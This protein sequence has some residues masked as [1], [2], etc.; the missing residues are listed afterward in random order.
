MCAIL[1]DPS[2]PSFVPSDQPSSSSVAPELPIVSDTFPLIPSIQPISSRAPDDEDYLFH[3]NPVWE[4]EVDDIPVTPT[5]A[6]SP[7]ASSGVNTSS[8]VSETPVVTNIEVPSPSSSPLPSR[9]KPLR[10]MSRSHPP[11]SSMWD[12][13]ITPTSGYFVSQ[14]SATPVTSV[15]TNLTMCTAYS[16]PVV[17]AATASSVNTPGTSPDDDELLIH[18]PQIVHPAQ[19]A[20]LYSGPW[21][22]QGRIG[23]DPDAQGAAYYYDYTIGQY[24]YLS[25]PLQNQPIEEVSVP[26]SITWN[27]TTFHGGQVMAEQ[28]QGPP[29]QGQLLY[30]QNPQEQLLYTQYP[31]GQL[32]YTQ[33]PQDQQYYGPP[34]SRQPGDPQGQ[35]YQGQPLGGGGPSF[36]H[37]TYPS[38]QLGQP[39]MQQAQPGTQQGYLARPS[40]QPYIQRGQ[41]GV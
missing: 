19:S 38:V 26:M 36:S 11:T 7:M 6:S 25:S 39:Y 13:H 15:P 23:I 18:I 27:A 14:V 41:L 30:A 5:G 12:P 2:I 4:P 32:L 34:P 8:H 31:Q 10:D 40:R 35:P 22:P 28:P 1:A 20:P 3:W 33:N 29:N 17:S 24:S 16:S 21:G 37:Q 9:Y